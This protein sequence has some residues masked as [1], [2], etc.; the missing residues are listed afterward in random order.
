MN[1]LEGSTI[2]TGAELPRGEHVRNWWTG[3]WERADR[4]FIQR[5]IMLALI[6]FL[7]G[8]ALILSELAPFGLPF[9]AAVYLLRK[10]RAP[11][12]LIG[13]LT[14]AVT[15]DF[16]HSLSLL[17][18]ALL[19][20]VLYK[21]REPSVSNQTK[22]M[23]ALVFISMAITVTAVHYANHQKLLLYDGLMIGAEAALASILT[24]IFMQCIPL[25][26]FK[27]RSRS[28]RTE[29]VVSVIIL[30]A[31]VMTGTIGWTAYDL[32]IEHIISRYLVLIFA[33]VGGAAIGS[34]VGVVTGLIFSLASVTTLYQMS[35]LAFSGLLG[36]LLKE[37]RK[38]G[39]AA[40]LMI[41]T[42]LIGLYGG[43]ASNLSITVWE[44][45]VAIALFM[46]TPAGYLEKLAKHIPGTNEHS[47]EQ[48]KYMRKMRDVTAQRVT[49]F[50][51]VFEALSESFSQMEAWN[52]DD[53]DNREV[54][55]F[56][57]HVTEKTCQTC[58][59][60][61]Q[62]WARN[63]QSTYE[64]MH[65]IM[66]ELDQNDL[67]K[68][69]AKT[70]ADWKKHCSKSKQV[71]RVIAQE[72]SYY[73]ANQKLKRQVKD[74]RRLVADQ[75]RGVSEV[76]GDFA[77]EIQRERENH[78]IQEEQILEAI[79]EFGIQ[80]ISVDIYSLEKG[81]ADIDMVLPQRLDR[82]ECEKLIAP[83]LSDILGETVVVT[84]QD[85][86]SYPGVCYANFR[87]AQNYIVE[88]GLASAAKGGGLVSGDSFAT[89]EIGA[90][91]FALA[92]S[93]GMGNGERAHQESK[94]TL[95]LLQKILLSGIEEKIAIKSV[96][97]IL[98]L[99]TTDEIFSTLDLAMID[100]QDAKLKFLKICST[101]SFVKRSDKVF[102]IESSN[103]PIGF[104]EEIEVEVVSEQLKAEDILIMFS[105]GIMDGPRNIENFEFW[106]K[107]KLKE[108]K[109]NNPQ[110]MA[111]LI[112]E[113]V[114]RSRGEIV[115]DMTVAVAKVKHNTPVWSAI[116]VNSVRK[117][118]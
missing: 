10:N 23:P 116:P 85:Y 51:D 117:K 48:Q 58:S 47:N 87:T 54:D 111:D 8:R 109:T 11:H 45:L 64:G 81:G 42:L 113:E 88:T 95:E 53:D 82:G 74:S 57:S 118:A 14:G 56:L 86:D 108:M 24:L 61:E 39:T 77:K 33:I 65:N 21:A 70:E 92:I 93:D 31:S 30:M 76:M 43:G 22:V 98:S 38:I 112:L 13:L 9:F 41:A 68:V 49:Q 20:M 89:M 67:Q 2:D 32:S 80:L 103:L 52:K 114:I 15:V 71:I 6:G 28:L 29:E 99:R 96:N 27:K 78:H 115:D 60:K 36:G 72:L 25:I 66:L 62:C 107:R 44:S 59:R 83:M 110:E 91:K 104:M 100:L 84:S 3:L 90:G 69:S 19:F 75:L 106:I 50:S 105:D 101:P 34:T 55:V 26:S 4:L 94:E 5:G 1:K 17:G 35:L 40:G 102:K 37:G 7:L 18:A 79:H 46:L 73:H 12:V 97:S 16:T 63:F